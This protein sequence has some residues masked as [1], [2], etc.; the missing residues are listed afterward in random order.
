[1]LGPRPPTLT[2]YFPVICDVNVYRHYACREQQRSIERHD[3]V[4]L[5]GIMSPLNRFVSIQTEIV[6]NTAVECAA[7]MCDANSTSVSFDEKRAQQSMAN[8]AATAYS[9]DSF[10]PMTLADIK[11]S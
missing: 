3:T 5:F 11:N 9:V 4:V 7:L 2:S 8:I 10:T 6:R 1:M